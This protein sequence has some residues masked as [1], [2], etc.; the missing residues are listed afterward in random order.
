MSIPDLEL[1]VRL[2][3]LPLG[4]LWSR[5][6][7]VGGSATR[8]ALTER[9]TGDVPWSPQEELF[10]AVALNDA[11]LDESLVFLNPLDD[12]LATRR[13]GWQSNGAGRPARCVD[14]LTREGGAIVG[15]SAVELGPLITRAQDARASARLIRT[16]AREARQRVAASTSDLA[17]G[18]HRS[19][20]LL[21]G[22][23]LH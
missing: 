4:E 7:A 8:H 14:D 6:L 15:V 17:L 2:V 13:P 9:V 16:S 3:G 23:A 19:P 22:R 10:L 21:D 20:A 12:L 5:Y 1:T 11:L 18:A